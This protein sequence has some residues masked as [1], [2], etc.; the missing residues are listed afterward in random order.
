MTALSYCL[1]DCCQWMGGEQ[2]MEVLTSYDPIQHGA[3]LR[4]LRGM[5]LAA[6]PGAYLG[7]GLLSR[8][9]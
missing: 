4:D 8:S 3:S 6:S 7:F 2:N 1:A 9:P 5:P